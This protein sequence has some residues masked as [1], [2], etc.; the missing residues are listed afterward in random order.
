M[1]MNT[2]DTANDE[3]R[4]KE[5]LTYEVIDAPQEFAFDDIVDFAAEITGCPTVF[6]NLIDAHRQWA[7]A[8]SGIPREASQC[9]REDSICNLVIR[10]NDVVVIPDT[11]ADS[12]YASISCVCNAPHLRFYAGAPLINSKGFALGTLCIVD[13]EPRTLEYD[14]VE[15]I[16]VLAR[17][18]V[19]HLELRK[20][21]IEAEDSQQKLTQAL[22]IANKAK[23]RS[24]EFL[25]NILP[26]KVA[27]EWLLNQ[28][29]LPKYCDNVTVG[30]T[31]FV[32]FTANTSATEPA[33][34]VSTLNKYFSA[35]DELCPQ[36]KLEKLKTIGDAY[37]FCSGLPESARH[38]A[39]SACLGSLA[40]VQTVAEINEQR[41]SQGLEPWGMRVGLHSGAVMTG[42][43]GK[44]KFSYDIWGDTVNT[45]ARFEQAC[46]EGR[47]NI[48]EA[49]HHRVKAYF[50]CS[51]RGEIEAK[52]KGMLK[53]Y[54]L[55]R[56]KPEYAQDENGMRGNDRLLSMLNLKS[57]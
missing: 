32:G 27:H 39:V 28:E 21:V 35:F 13:F 23:V 8:A 25:R 22:E 54:W 5:L 16:K 20:K 38:H 41:K 56:L 33:L 48:S 31:D 1:N 49:T 4:V 10:Q 3:L 34:L 11:L 50:D 52:N 42:I 2:I 6:I 30:F 44:N 43:V 55:D 37:M 26:E 9:D 47:I 19:A 36:F 40:F 57:I 46:E 17:Q 14:K 45:A 51:P 53:M 7:F 18:V 15:A 24:E 29:V 12:R